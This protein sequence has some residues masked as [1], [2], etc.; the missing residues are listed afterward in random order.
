MDASSLVTAPV[1]DWLQTLELHAQS[2]LFQNPGKGVGGRL[3]E[4]GFMASSPNHEFFSD[5]FALMFSLF[6]RPRV[7]RAH[8]PSSEAPVLSK[9]AFAL[10]NKYLRQSPAASA[11]WAVP[12]LAWLPFYPFFIV[13]YVGNSLLRRPKHESLLKEIEL[14]EATK[15]LRIR[16]V[17]NEQGWLVALRDSALFESPVH[18]VEFRKP[19]SK[20]EVLGLAKFTE[21]QRYV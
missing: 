4:T 19:M 3:F 7:H 12:P 1:A 16:E 17:S 6:S 14:V 8:S 9:K 11:L 18:D 10:M 15:Y 5:W 21:G 2:F 20:Y 13:H